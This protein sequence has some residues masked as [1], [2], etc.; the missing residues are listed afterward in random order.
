VVDH[1]H[2]HAGDWRDRFFDLDELQSLCDACHNAKSA[3]EM[4]RAI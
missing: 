3:R 2:G 4:P 1:K